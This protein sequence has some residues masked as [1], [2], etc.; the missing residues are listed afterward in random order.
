MGMKSPCLLA[1]ALFCAVVCQA[2]LP[3]ATISI[4][5]SSTPAAEAPAVNYSVRLEWR[6]AKNGTNGLQVV[7]GEGSFSLDTI[8][9]NAKIGDAEIPITVK[10]HGSLSVLDDNQAR[11]QLYLGR[12]VPYSTSTTGG[13][14]GKG[15]GSYS[16]MNVGLESHFIITFGKPLVI[17]VDDNGEVSILVKRLDK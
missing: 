11:L 9:G 5:N 3:T 16:Q 8:A 4:A 12:T 1:A 14:N 6:D 13:P 7:T 2:A 15:M 17:Q 10:F